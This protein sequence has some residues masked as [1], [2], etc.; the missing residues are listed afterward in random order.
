MFLMDDVKRKTTDRLSLTLYEKPVGEKLE[1][2]SS[3]LEVGEL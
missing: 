3:P 2:I 1:N